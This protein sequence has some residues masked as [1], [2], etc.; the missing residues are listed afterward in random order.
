MEACH[1]QLILVDCWRTGT[2]DW[3][4]ATFIQ[5]HMQ[6]AAVELTVELVQSLPTILW[7]THVS[8][9]TLLMAMPEEL[10]ASFTAL[11]SASGAPRPTIS[12]AAP[13]EAAKAAMVASRCLCTCRVMTGPMATRDLPC[14]HE[15]SLRCS[16]CV[17]S[18]WAYMSGS[19]VS[20]HSAMLPRHAQQQ[21]IHN[22]KAFKAHAFIGMGS[23]KC[24]QA[25]A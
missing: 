9:R 20:V 7:S 10:M 11:C 1:A 13:L 18:A 19:R 21:C 25:R 3:L 6:S 5:S 8:C 15:L 2:S 12:M 4:P 23:S 14:S 16:A 17:L 22:P 24:G